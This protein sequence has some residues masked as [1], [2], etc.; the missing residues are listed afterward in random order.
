MQAPLSYPPVPPMPGMT[1]SPQHQRHVQTL[2]A[3]MAQLQ[4]NNGRPL[5][6]EQ[7]EIMMRH[8]LTLYSGPTT[9]SQ[10]QVTDAAAALLRAFASNGPIPPVPRPPGVAAPAPGPRPV[11]RPPAGAAGLIQ[12]LSNQTVLQ[13][14]L[15]LLQQQQKQGQ[16]IS[17]ATIQGLA[18]LLHQQ[19]QQQQRRPVAPV[20][21]PPAPPR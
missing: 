5:S 7:Q 13:Q 16:P 19:Q 15:A 21:R 4:A 18:T 10:Q 12:A 3:N 6:A 2:V 20:V 17:Q 8:L 11:G 9:P 14:A 1:I